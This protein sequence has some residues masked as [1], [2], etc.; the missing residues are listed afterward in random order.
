MIETVDHPR[1]RGVYAA[2]P[3]LISRLRGSSPL[4][5][6]L[7]QG[8]RH[9]SGD[10]GIIPARAGFTCSRSR[11]G[12]APPDHPRSRGVY[13]ARLQLRLTGAG[14]SPLARGLPA[15]TG[16]CCAGGRIIPARAGFT[17]GMTV[18][19][20]DGRDHPRSRGVYMFPNFSGAPD[21][22]SSPLARGLPRSGKRR[23][24]VGR[25]I[26]ARAGFTA[27][28]GRSAMLPMDHPRSRGVY[29]WSRQASCP[30]SGSSPLAR[31]LPTTSRA[32]SSRRRI[33][34]ARAGFTTPPVPPRAPTR[35]HPRSRGV[36][37][38]WG[39][40]PA[41]VLGSSPLARGL[42]QNS[43][44][45]TKNGWIIPARAGFTRAPGPRRTGERDHPRSRGVY[46]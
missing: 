26:P 34:P 21:K 8:R 3:A 32:R 35:D 14:S 5:R 6:G 10:R 43:P 11:A 41:H 29:S 27:M 46:R 23:F 22:G 13:S 12:G 38:P 36:Y 17:P 9:L 18:M 1:S 44:R 39:I 4:A 28:T 30:L 16:T 42:P 2:R 40:I 33:I 20:K 25:I 7:P 31:G 37:A 24:T 45:C 19:L 15:R